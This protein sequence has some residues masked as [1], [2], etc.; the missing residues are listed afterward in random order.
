MLNHSLP[1]NENMLMDLVGYRGTVI[2]T[3]NL[4]P[5]KTGLVRVDG[6]LWPAN[7]LNGKP[8]LPGTSITVHAI[9]GVRLIVSH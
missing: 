5:C 7:S 3:V 6:E 8:L 1:K 2:Q 4:T 9:C